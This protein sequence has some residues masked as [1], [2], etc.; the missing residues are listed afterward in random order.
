MTGAPISQSS[1]S[2]E[3][4][5]KSSAI[6]T[7]GAP[8]AGAYNMG[9]SFTPNVNGSIT[10]LGANCISQGYTVT[11]YTSTGTVLATASV[12]TLGQG[13]W[14]YTSITPVSVTAGTTYVVGAYNGTQYCASTFTTPVTVGNVTINNSIYSAGSGFPTTTVTGTMYG[15]ADV[16]FSVPTGTTT[17]PGTAATFIGNVGVGTNSPSYTLD[18]QGTSTASYISRIQNLSTSTSA[19]GLL[20]D[21]GIASASRSTSN[22]FIGFSSAG[23][24]AGKIQGNTSA[25]IYTTSG[26]DYAEYFLADQANLPKPG[27]L[28]ALDP[29]VHGGVVKAVGGMNTAVGVVSTNPG[30]V[31]NGPICKVEDKNC[32]QDYAKYNALVALS[33]QVPVKVSISGGAIST[34]DAIG[35]SAV[36]GVGQ[37]VANGPI[38]GY[39]Q[40]AATTDKT[41]QVL[42]RPGTVNPT[43]GANLQA[44][45]ITAEMLKISGDTSIGGSLSV[46]GLTKVGILQVSGSADIAGALNVGG[47]LTVAG[48]S[49][50]NKNLSVKGSIDTTD[51]TVNGHIITG[52]TAP[53]VSILTAAGINSKVTVVGNDTSGTIT[54]TTGDPAV[55]ATK[56]TPAVAGP[57]VG[58]LAKIVF[59]KAYLTIPHILIAPSDAATAGFIAYP[60]NRALDGFTLSIKTAPA[61][62]STYSFEYFITQ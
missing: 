59:A 29:A 41:I 35:F 53:V 43:D 11:L 4:P 49:T 24:V 48:S 32:D 44:K 37:K 7:P 17:S 9:Y 26:A 12:T 40:E 50:I 2:P 55:L 58:D 15:L 61:P 18:V 38:V 34:G 52:G 16:T 1:L 3:T 8:S 10:A 36:P 22:Y 19:S 60:G 28:V 27:E 31:G 62:K 13:T 47:D 21:V 42:I 30:F 23:T 14:V 20:I 51:I 25:V 6:T 33:G 57:I 39:A 45:T 56:T 54:I 5:L 46:G